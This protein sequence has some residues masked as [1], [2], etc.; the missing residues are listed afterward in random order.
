MDVPL[1]CVFDKK[2]TLFMKNIGCEPNWKASNPVLWERQYLGSPRSQMHNRE[3]HI[4]HPWMIFQST[5]PDRGWWWART[6]GQ[7]DRPSSPAPH[8]DIQKA[9]SETNGKKKKIKQRKP[10]NWMI[11]WSRQTLKYLTDRNS[12]T[13]SLNQFTTLKS[14]IIVLVNWQPELGFG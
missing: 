10:V 12:V 3:L 6:V 9:I 1:H 11:E 7:I 5:W 8:T 13:Q 14:I 4:S 2:T